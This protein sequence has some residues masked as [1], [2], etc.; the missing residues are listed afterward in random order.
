[1]LRSERLKLIMREIN[2]YNKVLSGDLSEKLAVSEDTVRRDL[3]EL[4]DEGMILKVHGGAMS[5]TFHSP[6][7]VKNQVYALAAKQQIAEKVIALFKKNMQVMME[8]GTTIMEIAKKIPS[9]LDATFFTPSPQVAIT[10]AEQE[11][12]QVITIGGTLARNANLHTGA[13]VINELSGIKV[14]LCVIGA[15]GL[16]VKDGLTD[17]DWEVVQ[18]LKAMIRSARKVAVVSIAE[19]LNS[20]QRMKICDLSE[21]DYLVTELPPDSPFLAAFADGRLEII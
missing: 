11:D 4:A 7:D 13:S 19:K 14:D 3:K 21:I 17:L 20:V 1:M 8:G 2:L 16:T 12:V 5:K 9:R 15:N 6:F 18:V 10:L